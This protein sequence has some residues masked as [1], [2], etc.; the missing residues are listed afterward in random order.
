MVV[1]IVTQTGNIIA[2]SIIVNELFTK[3][4]QLIMSVFPLFLSLFIQTNSTKL[5][6][7]RPS[8]TLDFYIIVNNNW[9]LLTASYLF[10]EKNW[11]RETS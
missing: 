11:T 6:I 4:S 9:A 1:V 2:A 7:A 10:T 8:K 3:N 5:W